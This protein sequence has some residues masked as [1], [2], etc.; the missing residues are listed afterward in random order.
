MLP[1]KRIMGPWRI[2]CQFVK[3][4]RNAPLAIMNF[5][6]EMQLVVFAV[7]SKFIHD[8]DIKGPRWYNVF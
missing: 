1:N 5:L 3:W 7:T 4:A 2:A 8:I 6:K